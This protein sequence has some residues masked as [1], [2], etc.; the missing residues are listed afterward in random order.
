MTLKEKEIRNQNIARDVDL[1]LNVKQLEEKYQMTNA[2]LWLVFK[3][4]GITKFKRFYVDENTP[5]CKCG[6][7][8][9]RKGDSMCRVCRN[10]Y[11][12]EW[13]LKQNKSY[14]AYN[15]NIEARKAARH[16][17]GIWEAII[18]DRTPAVKPAYNYPVMVVKYNQL[19]R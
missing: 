1:G 16:H 4:L 8:P 17:S 12:N 10:A 13:A 15:S 2:A 14:T 11:R 3:K 19:G 9:R 5:C 6:K 18:M 7:E